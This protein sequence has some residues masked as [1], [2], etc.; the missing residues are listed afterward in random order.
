MSETGD[1]DSHS[2]VAIVAENGEGCLNRAL[3][4]RASWGC[5]LAERAQMEELM[6]A[7]DGGWKGRKGDEVVSEP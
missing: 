4:K 1:D 3:I 6:G 7:G 5:G 2:V